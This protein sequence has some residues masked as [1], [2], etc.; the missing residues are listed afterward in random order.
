MKERDCPFFFTLKSLSHKNDWYTFVCTYFERVSFN[1]MTSGKKIEISLK[2]P[3]MV[4]K[5]VQRLTNVVLSQ[6]Q[7]PVIVL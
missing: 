5:K 7:V 1:A 6:Y 3:T 2:T 4:L